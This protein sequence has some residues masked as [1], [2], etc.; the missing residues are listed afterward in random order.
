[1]LPLVR[2]RRTGPAVRQDGVP[3]HDERDPLKTC[4]CLRSVSPG[5]YVLELVVGGRDEQVEE[6]R[7]EVDV[8]EGGDGSE[9]EEREE[10]FWD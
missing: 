3:K 2:S 7:L 8:G 4:S 6:G 10:G 5:L 9:E 1:M